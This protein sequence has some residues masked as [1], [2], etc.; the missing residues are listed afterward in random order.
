MLLVEDLISLDVNSYTVL[1][2]DANDCEVT[3]T[4][5]ITEPSALDVS[6]TILTQPN[7][8][9]DETGSVEAFVLGGTMPY[10]ISWDNN[11]ETCI[12]NQGQIDAYNIDLTSYIP[13]GLTLVEDMNWTLDGNNG[14]TT[15][16]G[17]LLAGDSICTVQFYTV[18]EDFPGG[19][20]LVFTEINNAEDEFGDDAVDIDSTPDNDENNDN[21]YLDNE[22][23][24]ANNDEDDHDPV[25]IEV[26]RP[27]TTTEDFDT[28]AMDDENSIIE[29]LSNDNLICNGCPES[30]VDILSD[31]I[32]QPTNGTAM[33]L[34]DGTVLYEPNPNFTGD[35]SFVYAIEDCEG[36][37]IEENVFI[38]IPGCPFMSYESDNISKIL[39]PNGDLSNDTWEIPSANIC[40][41]DGE[42]IIFNRWGNVVHKD[43]NLSDGVNWDGTWSSDGDGFSISSANDG[44]VP[45]GTYFYCLLCNDA[46]A[47]Q[48]VD[49]FIEVINNQ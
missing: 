15:I 49:G 40:C 8:P 21:A 5:N 7:C 26:I 29:V 11:A 39:T 36:N 19:D 16:E 3:L 33:V 1:I 24:N 27:C 23:G 6:Y 32:V 48:K 37:I 9:T 22:I 2:T 17:P 12:Y 30:E 46:N 41:P 10:T 42:L 47:A 20:I 34:A 25:L 13:E 4:E 18:N 28:L 38:H 14:V 43:V 45:T 35:D 31:L 44:H